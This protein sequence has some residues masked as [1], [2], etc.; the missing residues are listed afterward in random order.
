MTKKMTAVT[1][2]TNE[3]NLEDLL[4]IG[5]S[6]VGGDLIQTV[7]GRKVH[8]AL[9]IAKDYT[10]WVKAQI[11]R[12]GFTENTDFIAIPQEG[13]S[14]LGG[15]QRTTY[16]FTIDSAKGIAMMS[17]S[18]KGAKV[19]AYFIECERKAL[20]PQK[21]VA[22]SDPKLAALIESLYRQDRLEQEQ[23]RQATE[24]KEMRKEI[25]LIAARTQPENKYF[26]VMGYANLIGTKMDM[27][28]AARIG[29]KCTAASQEQDMSIGSVSDPRFGR[30][31]SYHE[32]ILS[33]VLGAT[34]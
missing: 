15:R 6:T 4:P 20:A 26:T 25:L 1:E 24:V 9:G 11:T 16:H 3:A 27:A 28:A 8:A 5:A 12:A 13:V 18:P 32:S 22:V 17:Q 19:R 34:V 29:R 21:A 7:D 2:T 23:A 10:D 14:H 33:E 31:N 30:V